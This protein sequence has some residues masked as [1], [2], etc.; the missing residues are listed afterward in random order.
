VRNEIHDVEARDLRAVQQMHR[1]ALL[2]AEN[3]DQHVRDA[4]FLLARRLHVEHGALEH[5]LKAQ[6]RLDLAVLVLR[7]SRGR[8]IEMLVECVLEAVQVRAAGAQDLAHLGGV[9]NGQQQVL[10]REKF[11]AGFAR[12]GKRLIQTKFELLR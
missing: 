2:L 9:E 12:S 11:M 4:D 8:S 3:R 5:S 1:V 10:D 7:Q 6:G